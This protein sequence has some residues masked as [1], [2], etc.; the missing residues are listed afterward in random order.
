MLYTY[1]F[2]DYWEHVVT[3][4]SRAPYDRSFKCLDGCGHGVAEDVNIG[5][6]PELIEAYRTSRPNHE[7]KDLR[8]WYEYNASNGDRLGLANGREHFWDKDAINRNLSR[9]AL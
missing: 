3:S 7:Q 6:W 2:G 4:A 9:L 5:G 8:H 1:D